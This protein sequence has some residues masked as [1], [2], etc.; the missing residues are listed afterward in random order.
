MSRRVRVCLL[1]GCCLIATLEA[2][3]A[4]ATLTAGLSG[5]YAA[6]APA[7]DLRAELRAAAALVPAV[8]ILL[9]GPAHVPIAVQVV[10]GRS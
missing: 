5:P 6:E 2:R 7:R 8:P 3:R 4:G 10:R 1:A 9:F